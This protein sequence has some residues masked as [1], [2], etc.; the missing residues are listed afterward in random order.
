MNYNDLCFC[1]ACGKAYYPGDTVKFCQYCGS[2]VPEY[3]A[4]EEIICPCCHGAGKIKR[5]YG[6]KS[7]LFHGPFWNGA[8]NTEDKQ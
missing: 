4:N 6:K 3:N 5:G 1:P 7:D 8:T 2:K